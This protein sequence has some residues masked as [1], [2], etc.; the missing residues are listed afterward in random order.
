VKLERG[1]TSQL[2]HPRTRDWY[3]MMQCDE[4]INTLHRFRYTNLPLRE[5]YEIRNIIKS[6]KPKNT[7]GYDEI[8]NRIIKLSEPYIITP[9]TYICNTALN[10]GV[11]PDRLKY[12]I[13]KPTHKKSIYR[14]TRNMVLRIHLEIRTE[15]LK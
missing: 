6:L 11:F 12:A 2:H 3:E 4:I 5:Q 10:S 7:Y 9:F 14:K 13:V 8:S 15:T 1:N